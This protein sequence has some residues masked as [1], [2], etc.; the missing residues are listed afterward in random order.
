ME[1]M[2]TDALIKRSSKEAAKAAGF[3]DDPEVLLTREATAAALTAAGFP[4]ATKTLATKATRGGGPPYRVFSG[5]ALYRWG[6]TLDWARGCLTPPRR[7]TSEAE[8][9]HVTR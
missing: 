3:P 6:D 2:A 9:Q 4:V 8:A 5:R 1:H 7:S